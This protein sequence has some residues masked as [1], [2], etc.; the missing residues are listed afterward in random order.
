MGRLT[1]YIA[2]SKDGF[3]ADSNHGLEWLNAAILEEVDY[4]YHDFYA[5]IDSTIMGKKT[6]D[7]ICEMD[8]PFPYPDKANFVIT[9]RS[10]EPT[11]FVSFE[12][13]TNLHHIIA[14]YNST[15]LVGG[16][17][18][19]QTCFDKGL[20]DEIILTTIPVLLEN[21]VKLFADTGNLATFTKTNRKVFKNGVIQETYIK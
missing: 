1:L 18:I 6:Y 20:I 12:N 7:I 2:Q 10:F 3:I 19:N 14:K 16:S 9:S 21:G 17:V 5:S 4:G 15:W 11:E 13:A 8:V